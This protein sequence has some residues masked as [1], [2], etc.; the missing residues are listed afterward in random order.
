[1]LKQK[2][3]Y[4]S[5]EIRW[6]KDSSN[7][8][9]LDWFA[10]HGQTFENT[11]HGTDSYLPLQ[12]DDI[13]VKLRKGNI[14]IKHSDNL[15][16]LPIKTFVDYGCQIEYTL[17][18]ISTKNSFTSALEWFGENELPLSNVLLTKILNHKQLNFEN[19]IGCWVF[20]KHKIN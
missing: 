11:G 17:L 16:L 12:K 9:V 4:K 2:N 8:G 7:R 15:Q 5:K 20:F 3:M 6:F 13:T 14:E 1:M 18:E 19:S 10:G